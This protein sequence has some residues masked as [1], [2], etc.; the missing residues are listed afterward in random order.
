MPHRYA[1]INGNV[2]ELGRIAAQLLYLL[3]NN[4]TYLVKVC[5]TGDKLCERIDDGNNWLTILF[6]FSFLR[7]S[8]VREHLPCVFLCTNRTSQLMFHKPLINIFCK[9]T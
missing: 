1:I 8:I 4:L 6:T 5:V 9:G 3:L 7:Q 2:I